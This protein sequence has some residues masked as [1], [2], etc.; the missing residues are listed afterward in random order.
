MEAMFWRFP[1]IGEQIVGLLENKSLAKCRDIG[2][3]WM[4]FVDDQRFYQDKINQTM[5]EKAKPYSM[6][7]DRF[8][9]AFE[10]R[11]LSQADKRITR[12]SSFPSFN[13]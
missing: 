6:C 9:L 5:D 8:L 4:E 12:V 1:H 11:D 3:S 10:S 2:R 13:F 7:F